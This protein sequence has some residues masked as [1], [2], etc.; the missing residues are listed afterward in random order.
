[1]AVKTV[2]KKDINELQVEGQFDETTALAT[3]VKGKMDHSTGDFI[4]LGWDEEDDILI[5]NQDFPNDGNFGGSWNRYTQANIAVVAGDGAAKDGNRYAYVI[6]RSPNISSSS[7]WGGVSL[8]PPAGLMRQSGHKFRFSFDYRGYSGGYQM[9]V[10][11]NYSIG[12]GNFGIGLATPWSGPHISSFDTDWEWRHYSKE[13]TVSDTYLNWVAGNYD[14][15]ATTQYGTGWYGIRYNGDVYRHRSGRPAPTLGED[16][17]TT[18][19]NEGSSGPYDVRWV[20]GAAAGYFNLYR[21]MKIG[22]TYQSQN[23]RGTHVHI[24]N[25]TLTDITDNQAFTFD[26]TDGV[27]IAE[28]MVEEGLEILAKGTAYVSQARSDTGT[29]VF[30]VEGARYLSINGTSA[31]AA[32]GR[33]L[34][35]V[36]FN[37]SGTVLSNTTY[38]VYGSSTARNNLATALGGISSSD[39]WVLTSFDAI[40][41]EST[42]NGTPNLRNKLVSMGSRLWDSRSGVYMW[43]INANDVRNPYAAVGK[44]QNIL[45]EDGSSASDTT[46]KRK[47]VVQVR[48]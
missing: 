13:F 32:S 19:A 28:N 25:I 2:Y 33:G 15:N 4:G 12:W 16:P 41:S 37:S 26:L 38:D 30:A 44:G 46:Y 39:Y 3:N 20:G 7:T 48:V 10:Y 34:N 23:A 35:L 36:V 11:H 1:M 31:S 18:W 42:H 21:N 22:F 27:W 45:K 40:G 47:G 24:D 5:T 29:D 14:W 9:D 17:A 6:K 8:F 43:S